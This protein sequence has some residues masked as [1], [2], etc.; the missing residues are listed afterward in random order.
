MQV[1]EPTADNS[2]RRRP[3]ECVHTRLYTHWCCVCVSF[4]VGKHV[5]FKESSLQRNGTCLVMQCTCQ[6]THQHHLHLTSQ[7]GYHIIKGRIIHYEDCAVQG[8][9]LLTLTD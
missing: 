3:V 1:W 4:C 6:L 8:R 5:I 2:G 9:K 7:A